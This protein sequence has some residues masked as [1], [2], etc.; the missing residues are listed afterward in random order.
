MG[1]GAG[2]NESEAWLAGSPM[3]CLDSSWG[4]SEDELSLEDFL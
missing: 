1:E 3:G 2:D 4:S